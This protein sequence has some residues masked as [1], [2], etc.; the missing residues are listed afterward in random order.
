[1]RADDYPCPLPAE[2]LGKAGPVPHVDNTAEVT[3]VAVWEAGELVLPLIC[4]GVSGVQ[5]RLPL[6][7]SH[8][9]QQFR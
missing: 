9:L 8:L 2:A 4:P 7:C 5:V 3:L 1:M 6:P